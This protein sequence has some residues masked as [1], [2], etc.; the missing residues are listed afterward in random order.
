VR[1]KK[2]RQDGPVDPLA[3]PSSSSDLVQVVTIIRRGYHKNPAAYWRLQLSLE[4]YFKSFTMRDNWRPRWITLTAAAELAEKG[5]VWNAEDKRKH[6]LQRC[7]GAVPGAL[8]RTERFKALMEMPDDTSARDLWEF[9]LKHDHSVLA[10]KSEH[11]SKKRWLPHELLVIPDPP[12][13]EPVLFFED[14]MSAAVGPREVEWA[15]R[16][17]DSRA[18]LFTGDAP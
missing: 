5:G 3:D 9:Y 14:G 12:P 16:E 8:S 17:L 1:K 15:Q 2:P 10:L 13:G 4:S 11:K 7:H 18:R 6:P